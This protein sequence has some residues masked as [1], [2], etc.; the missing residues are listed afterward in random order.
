MKQGSVRCMLLDHTPYRPHFLHSSGV[1]GQLAQLVQ[2]ASQ[3]TLAPF[4]LLWDGAETATIAEQ[5]K[6]TSPLRIV[7]CTAEVT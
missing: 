4:V 1:Y 5:V 7:S 3:K 2:A 6:R